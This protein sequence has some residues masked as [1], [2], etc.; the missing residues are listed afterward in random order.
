MKVS[1]V[2]G[3]SRK[4]EQLTGEFD[5]ERQTF[6]LNR[7]ETRFG[8]V[9]TDLGASFEHSGRLYFLFGDSGST[10]PPNQWRPKDGDA[11]AFTTDTDPELGVRLQFLRAPDELYRSPQ[12]P[13]ISLGSFE[14]PT[15]GFSSAGKLYVFFTTDTTDERVMGRTVL[16]SSSTGGRSFDYLYDASRDKFINV[17]PVVVAHAT[18]PGLPPLPPLK[19]EKGDTESGVLLWG[20]GAYRQSDPYLAWLPLVS[21]EHREAW[22][23]FAGLDAVSGQP[24]WSEAE[25]D[26]VPLFAHPCIGELSVAWNTILQAWLMLY[27]CDE[28]RGIVY[29]V[30]GAPWGP[31]SAA[32]VLFEPGED[33][34]YCH[35]IHTNWDFEMCDSVHDPGREREWGGEYGPYLINAYTTGG[36][37]RTTIFFLMSTW[38]PYTTVL[39]Q[40]TLELAAGAPSP[41]PKAPP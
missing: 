32:A 41:P 24:R 34:G 8:L 4:V 12:V 13:G 26:A 20:S 2:P 28:P 5:R 40:A 15:G 19:G 27:N 39:M 38:N 6:T 11:I 30:A 23:Y 14:V 16:A 21:I 36:G 31:W 29:R 1:V 7:T 22:R 9:G 25:V 35:F 10:T 3:S 17:A 18:V 33:G 37:G